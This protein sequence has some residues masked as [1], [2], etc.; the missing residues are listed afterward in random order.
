LKL[1]KEYEVF[2][3]DQRLWIPD[4]QVYTYPDVMIVKGDLILQEG[5]K[6]TITNPVVIIEVLSE[7][8]TNYDRSQKFL[9]YRSIPTLQEYIIVD[10][11]ASSLQHYRK[12]SARKWEFEEF[13]QP[14]DEVQFKDI[15]C[16]ITMADIYEKVAFTDSIEE[17]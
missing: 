10:Q 5:R 3:S 7:S 6:D 17:A 8:T 13:N 4:Y 11:Y 2:V 15:P 9:F 12:I 14:T 16:I 1:P